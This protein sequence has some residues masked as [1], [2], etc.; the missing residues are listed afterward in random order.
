MNALLKKEIR[1][2]LPSWIAALSLAILPVQIIKNP[3]IVG[4]EGFF[5][6]LTWLGAIVLSLESFGH[7][8]SPGV[9]SLF[10]S[11]PEE[12]KHLWRVKV[13]ALALATASVVIAF[14]GSLALRLLEPQQ[15]PT[16]SNVADAMLV[17]LQTAPA[18]TLTAFAGG[19]WSTLL[20]R[21]T[22]AAMW[23]VILP[24][25]GI[26]M[27]MALLLPENLSV[28]YNSLFISGALVIYSIAGYFFA[29]WLFF[30]AQE[31]GW[32]GGT[33]AVSTW[34]YFDA[35]EKSSG[36]RKHRGPVATLFGKELQLHSI[37]LICAGVLLLLHVVAIALRPL[38]GS[39]INNAHQFAELVSNGFCLLW[40]IM[41]LIIGGMAVAEE[42]KLGVM[43]SLLC[44][45]AS[46]RV[47]FAIKIFTALFFGTMLG[48]VLPLALEKI[49]SAVGAPNSIFDGGGDHPLRENWL[50]I[51]IVL[52]TMAIS[53]VAFFA[54]SLSRNFL[55]AVGIAIATVLGCVL[56]FSFVTFINEHN[57]TTFF[58]ITLW[59]STLPI[60]IS[61]PTI[62][63]TLTW[64]AWLN[65]KTILEERR[66]WR[67]TFLGI[68][69]AL[70]FIVMSSATIYNRA[71]EIFEPAEPP[72]GAAKFSMSNPPK[73]NGERYD[74]FLV[75]L[76][77]GRVWFDSLGFS[78]DSYHQSSRLTEL[79]ATVVHPFPKSIGPRQFIE[80]SNWVSASA[81]HI[82][83]WNYATAKNSHVASGYLDTVGT[84]TDGTL[85][86]SSKAVP[87]IWTGDKMVQFGNDTDWR[88]VSRSGLGFLLLKTDGTLWRWGRTNHLDWDQVQ[89]NWPTVRDFKPYQIGTDS[90]WKEFSQTTWNSRIRKSDGSVWS[91]NINNKTG[92]DE[93]AHE[94]N[95]GQIPSQN[96]S[97]ADENDV[98]Y[99]GNDGTL[100]ISNRHYAED[101]IDHGW[102]GKG[103]LQIGTETNWIA[104]AVM[105]EGMVALKSDGSL[106]KWN[107]SFNSPADAAKI[108]AIRL[109]I[110]NDWIAIAKTYDGIVSLAAD[111]SLWLW[112]IEN[113]EDMTF[114]KLPKQPEFLG[115]VFDESD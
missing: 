112:P 43:E 31:V 67:R 20:L 7:E 5:V 53:L 58:G 10:M 102:H 12:R 6:L 80:G 114:L 84:K 39:L 94:T 106:W 70:I 46:R 88:Q 64:L 33:I 41:P 113:S 77:D 13:T 73:L 115:S 81:Q 3:A 1:L 48:G 104:V 42:R 26:A 103:F 54:S 22:V 79:W 63:V 52:G 93:L 34:K 97:F 82:D 25:I 83:V 18:L 51:C 8:F 99:I 65:F 69:G 90:D 17:N 50:L 56:F 74:N 76:P 32:T 98:A 24:P 109:G 37:S 55:Q 71:W 15:F 57:K 38:I 9:F 78:D 27:S 14:Y 40:L 47:Q 111:G 72:H 86:I 2:L 30:R 107:F 85:W 108:P 110:H 29:R 19:L 49:A 66:L 45:P 96:Y 87:E 21:Q 4:G 68:T 101:G 62:A 11:Q 35:G 100:W 61:I 95:F 60:L 59:H 44:L 75:R 92:E 89:T 28:N 91:A 105:W 16:N 23:F 36:K